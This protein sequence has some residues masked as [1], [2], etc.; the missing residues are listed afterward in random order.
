MSET[1]PEK[2]DN[3]FTSDNVTARLQSFGYKVK[4]TDGAI[5]S[6]CMEKVRSYIKNEVNWQ[7]IPEGLQHAAIDMVCGEF[8]QTKKAWAPDDLSAL[9][10]NQAVKQISTGDTT[11]VFAD[12]S[13]TDEQRLDTFITALLHSADGQY[14]VFRRLRW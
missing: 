6:F 12:G 4:D 10:L 5:I 9:D 8:L 11:T 7:D 13:Q 14:S 2:P 3:V 1:T